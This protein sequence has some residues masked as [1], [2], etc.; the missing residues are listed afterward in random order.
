MN[1]RE[2][3]QKIKALEALVRELCLHLRLRVEEK[4]CERCDSSGRWQDGA[5][6]AYCDGAGQIYELKSTKE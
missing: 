1:T 2:A 6:C 3:A 5:D 4:A